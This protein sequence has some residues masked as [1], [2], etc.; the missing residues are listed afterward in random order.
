MAKVCE[1]IAGPD[2]IIFT[3]RTNGDHIKIDGVHLGPEAAAI[4]A[5]LVNTENGNLTVRIKKENE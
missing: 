4:L 3:T 1:F 5:E 2:K